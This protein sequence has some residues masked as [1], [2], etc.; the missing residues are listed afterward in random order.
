MKKIMLVGLFAFLLVGCGSSQE[1]KCNINGKEAVFGLKDGMVATY[2]LD[3]EKRSREEIDE[4]NGEFF[5]GLMAEEDSK[6]ALNNYVSSLG[7]T[8]NFN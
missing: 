1:Y 8:C 5:T 7:G 3:G 2:T 6:T 4:I